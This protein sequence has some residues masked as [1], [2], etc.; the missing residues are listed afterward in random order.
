M[1]YYILRKDGKF[2][3][4]FETQEEGIQALLNI[5]PH[6]VERAK[7]YGGYSVTRERVLSLDPITHEFVEA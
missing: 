2:L 7:T 5:Q 4:R 6:H 1:N 3:S